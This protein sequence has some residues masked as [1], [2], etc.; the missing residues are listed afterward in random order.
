[1]DYIFYMSSICAVENEIASSLG[2]NEAM[3]SNNI[4]AR[5]KNAIISF[6]KT[7]GR[8][9]LNIGR[10]IKSIASSIKNKILKKSKNTRQTPVK[11]E[12]ED[13]AKSKIND[14]EEQIKKYQDQIEA[15]KN[16]MTAKDRKYEKD[17]AK[18]YSKN[19][20]EIDKYREKI[21][22][23]TRERD[24][25]E[26]ALSTL[27]RSQKVTSEDK[28]E[29]TAALTRLIDA[30][31]TMISRTSSIE[32]K[33]AGIKTLSSIVPTLKYMY[34]NSDSNVIEKFESAAE[35][36]IEIRRKIGPSDTY[37]QLSKM[38]IQLSMFL[39]EAS[40]TIMH[41]GST[42]TNVSNLLDKVAISE[43][44]YVEQD[45]Y[46]KAIKTMNAIQ[47]SNNKM[48]AAFINVSRNIAKIF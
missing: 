24:N 30:G 3:E 23:L 16:D 31:S 8:I 9:F 35:D 42:F 6:F 28:N 13:E 25:Y 47:T 27:S 46:D 34:Q 4:G 33:L 45:D 22:I 5:I 1:M 17:L 7:I 48:L 12:S 11:V 43:D 20:D 32:T 36:Y 39:S 44:V 29:L 19:H 26:S 37:D 10:S 15:L 41:A 2:N 18:V 38:D 40:N 14:L 21:L